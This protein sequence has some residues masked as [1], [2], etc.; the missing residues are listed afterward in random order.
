MNEFMRW[1]CLSS[2]ILAAGTLFLIIISIFISGLESLNLHFIL[3][4]EDM[5]SG[6]GILNAIVGS[7]MISLLSSVIALPFSFGTAIYLTKYAGN[8]RYV[9]SFRFLL[10]VL[11]GTPSIIIG[12]FGFLVISIYLKPFSGGWSLL[13]GSTALALLIAPVIERAIE[14]AI[15]RIPTELEEGSYA[16]GADKW[17][18]IKGITIPIAMPGLITGFILGFGRAAEESAVVILTA[19]YTTFL[20]EIGIKSHDKLAFGL[21]IYPFQ[22]QVPT[23]PTYIYRTFNMPH[24]FHPSSGF[25]AAFVLICIVLLI[26]LTAKTLFWYSTRTTRSPSPLLVSLTRILSGGNG[27]LSRQK[28]V[29]LPACAA[30]E[31]AGAERDAQIRRAQGTPSPPKVTPSPLPMTSEIDWRRTLAQGLRVDPEPAGGVLPASGGLLTGVDLGDPFPDQP[32]APLLLDEELFE[33]EPGLLLPETSGGDADPAL[34]GCEAAR[35]GEPALMEEQPARRV[36][37]QPDDGNWRRMEKNRL[38]NTIA[39]MTGNPWE[40]P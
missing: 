5:D 31:V 6:S 9:Q 21:K 26:N 16:L 38:E 35:G 29:P 39:G 14:D 4:S 13:S 37:E 17:G 24:F 3:T 33:D 22:D 28:P 23:L 34:A 40:G 8:T 11:S 1:I 7:I 18:T 2:A 30:A 12:V 15:I 36:A 20:P 19:G 25:A 32:A 10:E 27:R